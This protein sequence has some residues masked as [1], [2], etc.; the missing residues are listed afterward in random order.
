MTASTLII[1]Y[2]VDRCP[3]MKSHEHTGYFFENS[4]SVNVH[5]IFTWTTVNGITTTSNDLTGL[6]DGTSYDF[7]VQTVCSGGLGSSSYSTSTSFTTSTSCGIP[8]GLGS[9]SVTTSGAAVSWTAVPNAVS[10]NL[11]WKASSSST[12]CRL[13]RRRSVCRSGHGSRSTTSQQLPMI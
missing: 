4:W 8:T 3:I 12:W 9:S 5:S 1:P 2:S 10:Y 7:Q 13:A 6:A 11:Q